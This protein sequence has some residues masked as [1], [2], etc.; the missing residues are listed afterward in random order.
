[1]WKVFHVFAF[2]SQVPATGTG[3]PQVFGLFSQPW[4]LP[5][6]CFGFIS[7][8]LQTLTTHTLQAFAL[9]QD[10]GV[11]SSGGA[12]PSCPARKARSSSGEEL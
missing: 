9:K 7:I 1:M 10:L 12:M 5:F 6:T 11:L 8:H 4:F 2:N 3:A